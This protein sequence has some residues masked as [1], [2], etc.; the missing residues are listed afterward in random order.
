MSIQEALETLADEIRGTLTRERD[1]YRLEAVLAERK[2]FLSRKK[3]VYQARVR[4]DETAR[5][6]TLSER[7]RESGLGMGSGGDLDSSP[8]IGFKKETYRVGLDGVRS[9]TVEEQSRLLGKPYAY[10]FEFGPWR[11]KIKQAVEGAGFE[12]TYR[13][14]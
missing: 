10:R 14:F 2:A 7:L 12:L 6:V 11:E 1:G 5:Q 13:V 9:G 4:I 8:G 3:L